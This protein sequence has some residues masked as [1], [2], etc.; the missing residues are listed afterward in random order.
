MTLLNAELHINVSILKE[1][2]CYLKTRIDKKSNFL[3][4]V[5]AN[6]YGHSLKKFVEKLDDYV[7]GYALVRL[8]EA[9]QVRDLSKKPILL[10]QGIYDDDEAL[11]AKRNG[12]MCVLHTQEQIRTYSRNLENK[13]IWLKVNTGM[14]RL[15]FSENVLN[16][17]NLLNIKPSVLMSHLASSDDLHNPS[18]DK[19]FKVFNNIF[20]KYSDIKQR[21][22]L[23]TGGI[24]NFPE[25]AYDW[26]R[27]GIGMYGG[28][29][30]EENL[31]TAITFK[32]KII[33]INN[34]KKGESVGYGGRITAN[35][36]KKIASVYCGYAD[37]FPQSIIDGTKAMIGEYEVPIFGRVSMDIVTVDVT[38]IPDI[39]FGDWV[40]FWSPKNSINKISNNNSF[41]SYEMMT[42]IDNRVKKVIHED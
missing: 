42:R 34:V 17:L 31:K 5:K 39:Q 19:Q 22:I 2:I 4:V 26:V 1:N 9:L 32:S 13:N 12:F 27:C 30:G 15:G 23:N 18:N 21:S 6:A 41:I 36:D 29:N 33:S 24:I 35:S 8:D 16:D 28:F 37:G 40:E 7:D 14:N 25:H 10:M 38:D 3:A 11:I 20:E